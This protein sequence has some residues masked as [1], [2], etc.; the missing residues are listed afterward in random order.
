MTV[1]PNK[2][3]PL[4]SS[5]YLTAEIEAEV[6]VESSATL[7][8]RDRHGNLRISGGDTVVAYIFNQS[9]REIIDCR[10]FDKNDGT[11]LIRFTPIGLSGSYRLHVMIIT[12]EGEK[13]DVQ[14]SPY[15]VTVYPGDTDAKQTHV[16]SGESFRSTRIDIQQGTVWRFLSTSGNRREFQVSVRP[17]LQ[18]CHIFTTLSR[19]AFKKQYSTLCTKIG[20][21]QRQIRQCYQ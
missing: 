14:G 3:D 6:A 1:K 12:D 2:V 15:N 16:V 21:D 7:H 9:G 19:I 20:Y 11:Y 8:S 4:R 10:V 18:N 5:L 17:L 13:L